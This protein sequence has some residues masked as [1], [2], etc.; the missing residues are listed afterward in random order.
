[1]KKGVEPLS[2]LEFN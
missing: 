2:Y 1:M